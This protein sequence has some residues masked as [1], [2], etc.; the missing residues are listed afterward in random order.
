M[1][2]KDER[3]FNEPLVSYGSRGSP[4]STAGGAAM[5]PLTSTGSCSYVRWLMFAQ[6]GS[7]I[8]VPFLVILACWF[9][10]LFSGFGLFARFDGTVLA[11]LLFWLSLAAAVFLILEMDLPLEGLVRISSDPCGVPCVSSDGS[12]GPTARAGNRS[13]PPPVTPPGSPSWLARRPGRS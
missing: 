7:S 2:A 11:T 13:A 9:T 8:L 3:S 12:V 1:L 5:S 6:R 4:C 10:I